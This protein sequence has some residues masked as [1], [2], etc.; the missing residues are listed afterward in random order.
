MLY[1]PF[2]LTAYRC[3]RTALFIIILLSCC[4]FYSC[5]NQN[6]FQE[7]DG[8]LS[9]SDKFLYVDFEKTL[10][11]SKQALAKAEDVGDD[12][13]VSLSNYYIASSLI[14]FR[15]FEE[16]SRYL[17]AGL[18]N[19]FVQ[20]TPFLKAS[21]LSLQAS[22]YSRMSLYEQGHES[23]LEILDILKTRRD[24][25]SCLI[26]S[27]AYMG[28]ADYYTEQ[29]DYKSAHIY[30]DKAIAVSESIPLKHYLSVRKL[31]RNRAFLYFYKS[32]VLLQEKRAELAYPFIEKAYHQ[33]ALEGYEYL[34]PFYETYG[35]YYFQIH[36]YK[37]AIDFYIKAGKNKQKFQQFSAFVDSKIASSYKMLG[38]REQEVYYLQRA[39][40]QHK[41]DLK[42]DREIVQKELDRIL[43]KK[44]AEK[45]ELKKENIMVNVALIL[46]FIGLLVAMGVR[47]QEIRRKKGKIIGE[48]GLRL[49]EKELAIKE[50]EE[51]IEKLQ[52]KV[53]G[54]FSELSEMV[55]ENS[56]LFFGR[57]Q[58]IH[59]DFCARLLKVNP[60]LKVSELTFCAYI[61]LGFSTKEIAEYTFKAMK[62][63]ENNRYNLRKRLGLNPEE[64]LAVWIRTYIDVGSIGI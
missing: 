49:T 11:F 56:P 16:C 22:Y 58:E 38:N 1:M 51:K 4:H 64:D 54:A 14:F 9:Q 12:E 3:R 57:F 26:T 44:Q 39:E 37:K 48:Q 63:I 2:G 42:D 25:E 17:D 19:E 33:A 40:N 46:V 23:N 10:Q 53:T 43:I 18:H 20:K 15:R 7:I 62:T 59:P 36:D 28:I 32:W 24:P 27:K 52:Q 31:Y 29:Q 60:H 41:I 50:R 45:T 6:K 8:L 21:F 47:Y 13:R 55:K 30:A 35:D 61:Y 34:A 5:Q